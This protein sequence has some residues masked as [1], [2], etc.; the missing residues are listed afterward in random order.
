[1]RTKLSFHFVHI[2]SFLQIEH[3]RFMNKS[4]FIYE[5]WIEWFSIS[6]R[7]T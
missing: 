7:N 6:A 3:V 5:N 2:F 4:N 1:M